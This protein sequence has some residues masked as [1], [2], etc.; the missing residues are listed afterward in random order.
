MGATRDQITAALF[1]A[2]QTHTPKEAMYRKNRFSN[3]ANDIIWERKCE[4]KKLFQLLIATSWAVDIKLEPGVE[5]STREIH[6]DQN[7]H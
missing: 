1:L 3:C 6:W 2:L 7:T 5:I 4:K